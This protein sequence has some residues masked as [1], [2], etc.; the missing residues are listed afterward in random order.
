MTTTSPL[1]ATSFEYHPTH[2]NE[3]AGLIIFITGEFYYKVVKKKLNGRE[4]LVLEK[5]ADDFFQV[6]A[7]NLLRERFGKVPSQRSGGE[8]FHRDLCRDVCLGER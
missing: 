5:R 7:T 1:I 3:E 8:R 6:A 4:V 2:E